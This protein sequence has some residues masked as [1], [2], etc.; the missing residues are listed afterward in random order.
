MELKNAKK[1]SLSKLKSGDEIIEDGEVIEREILGFFK[2]LFNGH[3][4]SDL[5]NTG[6]SFMPDY[7]NLDVFLDRLTSLSDDARD[8]LTEKMNCEEL[9]YII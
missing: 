7:S 4:N 9:R 8:T 3:H 1:S 2:A 6:S 5:V